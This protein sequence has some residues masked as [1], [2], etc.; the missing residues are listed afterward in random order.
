MPF[1]RSKWKPIFAAHC[2]ALISR[3]GSR[4]WVA[5]VRRF[6]H[7]V[8]VC[9]GVLGFAA[10]ADANE[11]F[12]NIE[13]FKP[14]VEP[15]IIVPERITLKPFNFNEVTKAFVSDGQIYMMITPPFEWE[16]PAVGALVYQIVLQH[17]PQFSEGPFTLDVARLKVE[18]LGPGQRRTLYI[19]DGWLGDGDRWVLLPPEDAERLNQL[20]KTTLERGYNEGGYLPAEVAQK[21]YFPAVLSEAQPTFASERESIQVAT[22]RF[23]EHNHIETSMTE[24]PNGTADT[25]LTNTRNA[26]TLQQ[27]LSSESEQE[28]TFGT[29]ATPF[30]ASHSSLAKGQDVAIVETGKS[31]IR[32][33]GVAEASTKPRT[34][35]ATFLQLSAQAMAGLLAAIMAGFLFLKV[36]RRLQLRADN[37]P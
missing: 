4:A 35:G 3:R 9:M 17:L 27:T 29:L 5:H 34:S 19:M 31:S 28:P 24:G 14:S 10:A 11:R 15:A 8:A 25:T 21:H 12:E 20:L 30:S 2:N 37:R 13:A 26:S 18:L 33:E 1:T 36:Y 7:K 22:K 6:K 23:N 16:I 32:V